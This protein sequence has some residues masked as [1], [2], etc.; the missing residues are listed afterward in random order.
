M[1]SLPG[2]SSAIRLRSS[3]WWRDQYRSRGCGPACHGPLR[4]KIALR[5]VG[6]WRRSGRLYLWQPEGANQPVCY[7]I[8]SLGVNKGDR[9]AVLGRRILAAIIAALGALKNVSVFCPLFSAFGTRADLPTPLRGDAKV[10]VTTKMQF[11]KKIV[12][13][14]ERLPELKYILIRISMRSGGKCTL[15]TKS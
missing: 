2:I 9:V 1:R 14:R 15:S 6:P 4:D 12:E 11:K 8:R 7:L 5:L 13:I 3:E 10:L